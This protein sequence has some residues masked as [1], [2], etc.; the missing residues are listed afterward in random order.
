MLKYKIAKVNRSTPLLNKDQ[1][2]QYLKVDDDCTE[3]SE[4][5][6]ITYQRKLI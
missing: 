5:I 4:P 3:T 2:Y 1:P 6:N